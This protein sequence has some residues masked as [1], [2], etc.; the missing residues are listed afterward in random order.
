MHRRRIDRHD[1]ATS[2][3]DVL[4]CMSFFFLMLFLLAL[5]N[6]HVKQEKA[7]KADSNAEYFVTIEWDKESTADVDL[8]L[9]D[10]HENLAFF[11]AR[12]V[13]LMHLERDDLGQRNDMVRLPDGTITE[14]KDNAERITIRGILPGE[15][16]CNV[17]LYANYQ[18]NPDG[19]LAE[20]KPLDV[21]VKIE[22]L[23]P[24]VKIVFKQ[25]VTLERVGHEISVTRFLLDEEGEA[26]EFYV[27]D[28]SFTGNLQHH[29]GDGRP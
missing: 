23:N 20:Q 6:M 12:E 11:R 5:V 21:T 24:K 27:L 16:I 15:Y 26:V 18:T 3:L 28:K 8:Y 2:F 9:Q 19:S 22:K 17:H 4:F 10:P 13:G 29:E 1:D 25:I 14:F 7:R